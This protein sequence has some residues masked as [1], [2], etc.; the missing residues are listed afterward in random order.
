[1]NVEPATQPMASTPEEVAKRMRDLIQFIHDTAWK[2]AQAKGMSQADFEKQ[3]PQQVKAYRESVI[4]RIEGDQ[5]TAGGFGTS[6]IAGTPLPPTSQPAP[7]PNVQSPSV[8]F[9]QQPDV[10]DF[11]Q[12]PTP[13]PSPYSNA[14]YR[15][16][17][18]SLWG[19]WDY[20]GRR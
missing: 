7:D 20:G 8:N 3:W 1:V 9:T 11:R 14:Q 6:E 13:V 4:A 2:E 5:P 17:D 16:R 12:L 10:G 18:R 19:M 15:A